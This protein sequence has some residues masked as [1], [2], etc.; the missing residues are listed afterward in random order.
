MKF[1]PAGATRVLNDKTFLLLLATVSAA[2]AWILWPFYATVFWAVV[3]AIV[4][5]PLDRRLCLAMGGR[6]TSAALATVL[7]IVVVVILPSALIALMLVHEGLAVYGRVQ[8]GDLDFARYVRQMTDALPPWMT[9]ALD[10]FGVGSLADVRERFSAGLM[11]GAQF[12]AGH[13]VSIGQNAFDFVVSFII[14]LYLL[15]FLLRDG[16][17]ITPRIRAAI[18]LDDRLERELISKFVTVIRA[19]IKGNIVI[20]LVQGALGGLIFWLLDIRAAIF[21]AVLMAFLSLLPAVG[22]ALVWLP[23][24]IYFLVTGAVWQGVVLIAY[25]VLVIGLVDNIARPILVGKDTKMPD[26]LVL[27][28]TLGGMAVFGINGFVIGPVIAAMFLAVWATMA[29][30]NAGTREAFALDAPGKSDAIASERS[31]WR[32]VPEDNGSPPRSRDTRRKKKRPG[33]QGGDA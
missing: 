28:S 1:Q 5:S 20:A 12:L 30:A 19:T 29:A 33:G 2:F 22:T 24:A 18:P 6:R 7:A 17:E 31:N 26:Y 16:A 25:G 21:W 11:K 23:V 13:A 14:M 32:R 8:S 27:I 9:G 15:F 3:L 10:R 4:F